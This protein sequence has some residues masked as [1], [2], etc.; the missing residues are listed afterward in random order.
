M[1]WKSKRVRKHRFGKS[2][3]LLGRALVVGG[4]GLLVGCG[5][6]SAPPG[7]Y[8]RVH[9]GDIVIGATEKGR[10]ALLADYDFSRPVSL[11]LSAS[12]GGVLLY[13]STEPG[14]D[15]L[16]FDRPDRR[17]FALPSGVSVRLEIVAVDPGV[18]LK[19]ESKTLRE[20]G[21]FAELGT[22]PD[23]HAH[24]EWQVVVPE[25][26]ASGSFKLVFR[27]TSDRPEFSDSPPYEIRL[28][29]D[30]ERAS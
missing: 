24:G 14:F 18:Q 13:S 17:Q 27:L 6:G 23:L 16:P 30:E 4:L 20:P 11:S 25:G 7:F 21:D 9:R 26:G 2:V 28:E 29:I 8:D 1:E 10:G 12:F 15:L 3:G 5:P 22:T 19:L